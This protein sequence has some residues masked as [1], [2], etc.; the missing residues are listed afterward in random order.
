MY[1]RTQNELEVYLSNNREKLIAFILQK[2]GDPGLAE[3]VLQESLLKAM[4]TARI[5]LDETTDEN[6]PLLVI[7]GSHQSGKTPVMPTADV[8]RILDT[9][10]M[11]VL[12]EAYFEFAD[13]DGQGFETMIGE[14]ERYLNLVVLRTF[15][16]WAGLAG[17]RV[18]YGA[19][20][21]WLMPTLWKAKQPY[22]VSVAASIA[23]HSRSASEARHARHGRQLGADSPAARR[24]GRGRLARWPQ[25]ELDTWSPNFPVFIS[26]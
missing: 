6:G 24:F 7:P 17:L 18:G 9:G 4:L 3:D 19:F 25:T 26:L 12:D 5:H 11:V 13:A 23:A 20:P 16:K 8:R 15:S 2:V 14:V 22:N 21:A 10:Y 1:E